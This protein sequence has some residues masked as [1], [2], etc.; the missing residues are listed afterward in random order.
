MAF[1]IGDLVLCSD[2][3]NDVSKNPNF[4]RVHFFGEVVSSTVASSIYRQPATFDNGP[5]KGH[6]FY[7]LYHWS[8]PLL[9]VMQSLTCFVQMACR[10]RILSFSYYLRKSFSLKIIDYAYLLVDSVMKDHEPKLVTN[11]FLS[12]SQYHVE[13]VVR[14]FQYCL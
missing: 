4:D 2:I 8:F 12:E 11:V 5:V 1:K 6:K 10:A 3:I 9:R 14:E 13:G 7:V